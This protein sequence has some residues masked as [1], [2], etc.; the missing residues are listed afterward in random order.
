MDVDV[1]VAV[2]DTAF[3]GVAEGVVGAGY[4]GESV[5]GAGVVAVAVWVVLEG[6]GV[7]FPGNWFS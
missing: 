2:V 6:E 3:R 4:L 1:V 5:G 7:E